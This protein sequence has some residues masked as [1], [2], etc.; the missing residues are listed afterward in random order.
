M[1]RH[2]VQVRDAV[3]ED[4]DALVQVW[5]DLTDGKPSR[6]P[7]PSLDEAAR[8]IARGALDPDQRLV[9][10]IVDDV[11]AGVACVRRSVLSPI[12]DDAAVLVEHLYVH[13]QRRRQ[14]VGRALLAAA[15]AWA[16]EKQSAHLMASVPA[17][18]RDANRFLARLGLAQMA[19]VRA[20]PVD[21]LVPRLAARQTPDGVDGKLVAARRRVLRR[22]H[23]VPAAGT[24][25]RGRCHT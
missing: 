21:G 7:T 4:A 24:V 8:A 9:V 22:R 15:A 1:A 17:A 3:P 16:D 19:T 12:H 5:C 2:P 13:S 6:L 23:C 18:S 10:G 14:G 11:V 20:A 25:A